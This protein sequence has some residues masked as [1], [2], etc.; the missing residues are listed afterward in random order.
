MRLESARIEARPDEASTTEVARLHAEISR[1]QDECRKLQWYVGHDELTGLANRRLFSALAPTLLRA[2]AVAVVLLLD[3]NGFKPIND[4]YGHEAGDRV[5]QIVAER[6]ERQIEDGLIARLGGDEF[7]GVL[8]PHAQMPP[9][10]WWVPKVTGLLDTLEEP[11]MIAGRSLSVTASIGVAV[12]DPAAE[13]GDLMH[14]ADMAMYEA[15]I[16][17]RGFRAWDP[18]AAPKPMLDQ[19]AVAPPVADE[20][21]RIAAK[22]LAATNVPTIDPYLRDP[23]DITPAGTYQPADPVWVFRHGAW[24]PGVVESASRRAV[25][26]TYRRNAGAGT[27]VDTMGA[28]CV[29]ER[30]GTDPQLDQIHNARVRPVA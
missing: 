23:V 26:A 8:T 14:S 10:S 3:L 2:S 7:V 16:H 22:R 28:E 30:A 5:L 12:A 11:M 9:T 17:G 6:L 1:L 13:I 20:A 24:H 18:R 27:V 29:L 19:A 15:K 4:R 21:P 25:M